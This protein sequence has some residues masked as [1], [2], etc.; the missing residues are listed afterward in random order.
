MSTRD[1]VTIYVALLSEGTDA[2]RPTQAE[3]LG[4]GTYRLL[5]TPTYDR[6]DEEWEFPPGSVVRAAL[7]RL[8][9]GDR[10]V[11]TSLVQPS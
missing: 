5:A 3:P 10:L 9:G 8:S 2:W 7:R 4:D 6:D 11:A 1:T